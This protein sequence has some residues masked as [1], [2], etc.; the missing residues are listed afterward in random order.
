MDIINMIIDLILNSMSTVNNFFNGVVS[1]IPKL[2]TPI[3]VLFD[4][5]ANFL[6][7]AVATIIET[8][9]AIIR[10]FGGNL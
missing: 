9:T 8:I 6:S 5:L 3:Q 2:F 10:F 7:N 4:F 1:F